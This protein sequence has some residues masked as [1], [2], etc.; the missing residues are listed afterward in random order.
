VAKGFGFF[1][2]L[3]AP[4]FGQFLGTVVVGAEGS[5]SHSLGAPQHVASKLPEA[6]AMPVSVRVFE[7]EGNELE[8][9]VVFLKRD[10]AKP[11]EAENPPWSDTRR[12]GDAITMEPFM[13]VERTKVEYIPPPHRN[14]VIEAIKSGN[15]WKRVGRVV[16]SE[17]I[18]R[19]EADAGG[20]G[21]LTIWIGL[22]W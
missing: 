4:G 21:R 1:L 8:K 10:R 20:Y 2:L 11:S 15:L 22:S 17:A 16:T 18:T 7:F 13:V 3:G 12:W 19:I 9:S 5:A 6:F 14:R